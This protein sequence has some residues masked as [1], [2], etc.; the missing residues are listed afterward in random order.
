M[1]KLYSLILISLLFVSCGD[2]DDINT[3]PDTP[4]S[5]NHSFLATKIILNTAGS[6][7]GKWFVS[8]SWIIKQT[9]FTE[10]MEDYLY[11][12]FG[13]SNFDDYA[14]LKDAGKMVDLVE[15]DVT[16]SEEKKKAYRALN[17][18]TRA[19]VFYKATMSF[20][21]VPCSEAI[22]GETEAIYD[23][24]YDRQEI[25][26]E[27]VLKDLRSASALFAEATTFEGDPIYGGN[28]QLWRKAVNS[29]T[30][31]VLNMANK[32]TQIGDINVR[33][34]F[35]EVAKLPLFE[36]EKESY[37]QV[38]SA[39]KSSQWYPF[40]H[41]KQ[42]YWPFSFMTSFMVEMMKTLDDKRLFYYAEPAVAL[43]EYPVDSYD[44]Y[45]GVNPVLTYGIIQDECGK[46]LHSAINKRYHRE[47]SGEPVKIIA[48]SEIQFVLAEAALRGWKTPASAKEHYENGVRAAMLFT[49]EYTPE[50]YR[51]NVLIDDAYI[52][53]Y[54]QGAA[55]FNQSNGLEQ[56]M[57]QKYISSL[58]QLSSNP[59]YDYRRTGL[60]I[61]PIDPNTNLNEVKNQLPLR[62][63][64]PEEEYSQNRANI[65]EA[66]K[67]QFDG[68][69]TP[70]GVMWILK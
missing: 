16:V 27:T 20:G 56:I 4:T 7:S 30:L 57:Q 5:V 60:P 44:A 17:L 10:L 13:R 2:L 28:V 63:M 24:Q 11:N 65:E 8:D 61:L 35:E 53:S 50:Q 55:T 12:K 49:A 46:G 68:N 43:G 58:F 59:Y 52:S 41:E 19:F 22:K 15:A 31:R 54:L 3:N 40:Y 51:H 62:W 70:N 34:M 36:S 67:K 6:S 64:Y 47:A 32:K 21:D 66:I 39:N 9:S 29:F 45:S 69:D 25:V 33:Q 1:R 48:Y 26:F 18:F 23:P 38:Y 37:Q 42:N 14:Y